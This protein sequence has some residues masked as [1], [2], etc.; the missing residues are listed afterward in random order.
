MKSACVAA[1]A[2]VA[3]LAALCVQTVPVSADPHQ[4]PSQGALNG[5][6]IF[7]SAGHGFYWHSTLGWICQRG[8]TNNMVEDHSNAMLMIDYV[9]P[10]LTNA[11]ATVVAARERSY[12]TAEFVGDDG[13]AAYSQTGSWT[14]S[15]SVAGYRG[16]GYRWASTSTTES[17][18]ARWTW[19]VPAEGRY[20][21]YVWF[22]T[23]SDRA[24]DALYRVT[25]GAGTA[26][27][28][29]NQTSFNHTDYA[30]SV[31][32]HNEG[33]RWVFLGEWEFTPAQPAVLELS[34]QSPTTGKVVIADGVRLGAGMGSIDR[35]GGTSGRA[36]W[37]ECS[38]YWGEYVGAPAS[39]YNSSSGGEDNGDDVTARPRLM[40]WWGGFDLYFALH[41]NASGQ[42]VPS[43]ARGTVTISYDN[44]GTVTHP[45][46]L[47][48]A[49]L[50]LR[51]LMNQNVAG[52]MTAQYDNTWVTRTPYQDNLGECRQAT[53]APSCLLES[54]FHDNIEDSAALRDPEGRHVI[55]RAIYKAIARYFNAGA[56]IAP[57]PPTHLRAINTVAGEVTIS[58][59]GQNDPFEASANPTGYRVYLSTDGACFDDGRVANG[60]SSHIVSGLAPGQTVYARVTATNAGGESLWSELICARTPDAAAAGLA[61][62]LLLVSGYDRLDEFTW[63]QQGATVNSGDMHMRNHRDSLRRH[64]QAA[65]AAS[66][67]A[68]GGYFFDSASNESVIAGQVNLGSY[69]A[70]DW[71]LGNESTADE[72][73]SA[74]EQALVA[75]Y[76]A[77][78]GAMFISGSEVAW[79]L[80][81]QGG[82]ADRAFYENTLRANY[83]AD[84]SADW[85]VV[86]EAGS[87]FDG[88]APFTIDDGSGN[89][90]TVG[91]P[92][93]IAAN[94]GS[95]ACLRYDATKVAGLQST[96]LIVLGFPFEA[97]NESAARNGLM[98]AGLRF[99]LAGYTG[100]GGGT[101]P[102]PGGG[103][104]GGSDSGD[105][106]CALGPQVMALG[107]IGL[108]FAIVGLRRRRQEPQSQ[109]RGAVRMAR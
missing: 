7:V 30:G 75:A 21:V 23:G 9:I 13:D 67:S 34:N 72:T 52:D 28:R 69:A 57:L 4:R 31:N 38:R 25:H 90:Y 50:N 3:V 54:A 76:L 102:P 12:Q 8:V 68:G 45:T 74:T 80:D 91:Y 81:Q 44:A 16:T 36:R 105:G 106:G 107:P 11:G 92:D 33:A 61:T 58:W 86:A 39:V 56:V 29:V 87:V 93:V 55:G 17:A 14:T 43:S 48:N 64:A 95:T 79:D 26:E 53:T 24:T 77:G 82:T 65:A 109:A 20:P 100:L 70:V 85:S 19:T 35:G 98:Q 41:S 78:G 27:V 5:K 104:D 37:E 108:F 89:S 99:T 63:Y 42:P 97:I 46:A 84:S 83:V 18:T 88:L 101:T 96:N 60:T 49:S 22:T 94:A 32:T 1:L 73:F 51:N 15:T 103:S 40:D 10:Y 66:T 2:A 71:V 6:R 59:Q 47:I 62:P